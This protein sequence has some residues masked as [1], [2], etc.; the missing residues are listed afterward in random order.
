MPGKN[1]REREI[2]AYLHNEEMRKNNPRVGL[3][4]HDNSSNEIKKYEFDVHF[5]PNLQWAGKK[6]NSSF[7][8]PV[9]SIHIHETVI[10]QRV[11]SR[12]Q[13][14]TP[15][16]VSRQG[17]LFPDADPFQRLQKRLKRLRLTNILT[18]GKIDSLPVIRSLL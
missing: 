1:S 18:N 11:I 15:D 4:A 7:D 14:I 17:Y 10:P 6:E 3:A 9:S 8:V 16:T 13:N 5:S 12:L 2:E